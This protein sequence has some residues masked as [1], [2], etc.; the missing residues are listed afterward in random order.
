MPS[1]TYRVVPH[2]KYGYLRVQPTPSAEEIERFYAQ[3]FYSGDYRRFNDSSLEAQTEDRAWLD[4]RRADV[5][6]DIE[7]LL[8]RKASEVS[9]LDVG[10]GWGQALLFFR[11]QGLRCSGFDPVP[12]AV[13]Y[14]VKRGLDVR[15][16]GFQTLDVFGRSFDAITLFNVL[17][18]LA[19]P[20]EVLAR[21]RELLVPGG[22][23]F[24]DVPN[25][26]NA[27]QTAGRELHGLPEWWVCPPGH[28][29]YFSSES[30]ARLLAGVGFEVVAAEASFP[31]E[32]FLLFGDDYTSDPAL[33]KAC[34][35]KRVAFELNLRRL[36]KTEVLRGFYRALAALNLGRQVTITAR[37]P[38]R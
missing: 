15:N 20:D 1:P 17:E 36:G 13:A 30:L 33:G 34:H 27:F 26:Y 4:A 10:C 25:E 38:A 18:H 9:L 7:H 32:M 11:E 23:L 19:S 31:L 12:E 22:L 24:V 6:A 3:E 29:N 2:E 21:L 28:L 16:A 35:E 37:R 14:A 5:V 8:G